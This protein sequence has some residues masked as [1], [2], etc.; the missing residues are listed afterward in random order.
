MPPNRFS[1]L[2]G[3]E[4]MPNIEPSVRHAHLTSESRSSCCFHRRKFNLEFIL[5]IDIDLSKDLNAQLTMPEY[6]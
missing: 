3:L 5:H 1:G 2:L 6:R 4:S